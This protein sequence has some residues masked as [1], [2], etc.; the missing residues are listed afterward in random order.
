MITLKVTEDQ[1]SIFSLENIFGKTIA[2]SLDPSVR[3]LPPRFF[4]V[5][6]FC[7]N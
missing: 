7:K 1:G 3:P 4:R 5:E 2:G 6:Y